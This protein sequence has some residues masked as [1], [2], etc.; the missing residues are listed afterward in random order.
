VDGEDCLKKEA[1]KVN[2]QTTNTQWGANKRK[3]Q[4]Q[5]IIVNNYYYDYIWC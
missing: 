5:N 4:F 2:K 1:E 3:I